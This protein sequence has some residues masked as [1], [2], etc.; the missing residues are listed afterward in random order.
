[1]KKSRK[2]RKAEETLAKFEK[3]KAVKDEYWKK[4]SDDLKKVRDIH[5]N[6]VNGFTK[7]YIDEVSNAF[8]ASNK[9]E[10]GEGETVM[11]NW[12]SI[13]NAWEGQ[14]KSNLSYMDKKVGPIKVI[15]SKAFVDTSFLH[16]EI[17]E[18]MDNNLDLFKHISDESKYGMFVD[19]VDKWRMKRNPGMIS[20][21]YA[22]TFKALNKKIKLPTYSMSE[23]NFLKIGSI[24]ETIVKELWKMEREKIKIQ[25]QID[26]YRISIK[27]SE[28]KAQALSAISSKFYVGIL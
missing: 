9:P 15:V 7:R 21:W 17:L 27:A 22:Y 13:G 25:K 12:Y 26:N 2:V 24:E 28:E 23:T 19:I 18:K 14:I 6:L 20:I 3:E 8:S 11:L 5:T 16:E 10:F 1:M 4:K